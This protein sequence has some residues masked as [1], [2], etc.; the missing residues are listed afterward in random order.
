MPYKLRLSE[1]TDP[2]KI[3]KRR[4][5]NRNKQRQW[6]Q[7][8]PDKILKKRR[9]YLL[10]RSSKFKDLILPFK[11]KCMICGY[12]KHHVALDF[13]HRDKK[14]KLF[15]I[16]KAYNGIIAKTA[17]EILTEIKKCDVICSNCHRI[18]SYGESSH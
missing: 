6:Y 15:G 5:S 10:G 8:N 3:E 12:D 2:K 11:I 18:L 1:E 9:K 14:D 17:E 7:K 13:H 16:A 4:E